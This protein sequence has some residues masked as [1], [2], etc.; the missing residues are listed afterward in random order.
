MRFAF[1]PDGRWLA[2]GSVDRTVLLW[3]LTGR[4]ADGKLRPIRLSSKDRARLWDELD[5]GDGATARR[6]I[7]EFVAGGGDTVSF[8]EEKLRSGP[9]VDTKR[10]AALIQNVGSESFQ[11]RTKAV[12]ALEDLRETAEPWVRKKL[13]EPVTLEVQRRLMQVL[14]KIDQWSAQHQEI[15]RAV[16][17]LEHIAGAEARRVLEVLADD[18]ARPRLA[19]E[20]KAAL[21]RLKMRGKI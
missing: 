17:I 5:V 16:E 2:S 21:G 15:V 1:S 9:P 19:G 6:A 3:D 20:A 11:V 10:I 14:E 4:I 8:M 7:W 18:E 12:R 13:K